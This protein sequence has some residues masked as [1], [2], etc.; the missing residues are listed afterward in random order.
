MEG[1]DY[2]GSS[3]W[4]GMTMEGHDYGGLDYGGA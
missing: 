3:L 2:G 4:R 1:L